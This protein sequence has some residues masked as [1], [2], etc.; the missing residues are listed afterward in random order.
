[1]SSPR[2]RVQARKEQQ[3]VARVL[4]ILSQE[5]RGAECALHYSNPFQLLIATIL[6][7]QCTDV[8]VNK[9]TPHLFAAYSSPD[10]LAAADPCEVEEIIRSTGFFRNKTKSLIGAAR[11]IVESFDGE[12][13]SD[14]E[15]LL[16]LPG[17]ARK[18][19][20]VVLGT[21]FGI[22][23]GVVV[24][25]HVS[26]IS[27]RLGLTRAETPVAIEKDLMDTIEARDWIDFSHQ[28]IHHGRQVCQ[29]RRPRCDRCVLVDLC[30]YYAEVVSQI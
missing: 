13:P 7:A 23:A 14:M 21:G 15:A 4:E 3:R 20:N 17:V 28:V 12:V 16:T 24:D 5:Y 10:S 19:A 30:P 25:T 29:A 26:R 1:M 8:R 27:R 6:S 9:V 18:T 11:G 22:A 2:S